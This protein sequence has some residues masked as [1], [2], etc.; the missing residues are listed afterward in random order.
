MQVGPAASV[1]VQRPLPE[2]AM[3]VEPLPAPPVT[4]WSAAAMSEAG[5]SAM[6][7][8]SR[9]LSVALWLKVRYAPSSVRKLRG[10]S[11]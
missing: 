6:Y 7:T 5:R 8:G 11:P 3:V 4:M 10:W 9:S 1:P 2:S